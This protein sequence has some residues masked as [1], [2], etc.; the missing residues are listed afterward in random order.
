MVV[1]RVDNILVSGNSDSEH[2]NNPSEVL[3][4]LES[5]GLRLKLDKCKL[6]QPSVEYLGFRIGASA[7]HAIENKVQ[8]IRDAPPP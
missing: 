6:M 4:R 3:K 1:Y 5:A 7:L 2:L 8:A